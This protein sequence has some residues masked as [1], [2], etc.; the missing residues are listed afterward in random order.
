MATTQII[1]DSNGSREVP[2]TPEEQ[3]IR[4]TAEAEWA[5]DAP[6]KE[7]LLIRDIRDNLLRVT[8]W[9]ALEGHTMSDAWKTYRQEL[10]DIPANNTVA[11]DVTWPTKPE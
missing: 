5:A 2:F 9:M 11:A 8:D 10:R 3:V 1:I 4:D 7:M 6:L